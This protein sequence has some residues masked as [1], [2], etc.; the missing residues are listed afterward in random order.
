M[1]ETYTETRRQA[2]DRLLLEGK[3]TEAL[4]ALSDYERA[5]ASLKNKK[6]ELEK[7]KLKKEEKFNCLLKIAQDFF[8]KDDCPHPVDFTDGCLTYPTCLICNTRLPYIHDDIFV[9]E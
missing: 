3:D 6:A 7:A 5:E 8:T 1:S 4:K 2:F 9:D